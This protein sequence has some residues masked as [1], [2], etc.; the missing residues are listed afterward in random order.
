MKKDCNQPLEWTGDED[1]SD[2]FKFAGVSSTHEL[3]TLSELQWDSS[4]DQP[5]PKAA[6]R[7]LQQFISRALCYLLILTQLLQA[8][9]KTEK[10]GV[11]S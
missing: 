4:E 9:L 1:F 7:R 5:R 3:K 8:Q 11:L 2:F 10:F 6:F